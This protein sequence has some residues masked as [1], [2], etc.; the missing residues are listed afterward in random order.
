MATS[1]RL[2]RDAS[3]RV[4]LAAFSRYWLPAWFGPAVNWP[5]SSRLSSPVQCF[6]STMITPAAVDR[7]WSALAVT[8]LLRDSSPSMPITPIARPNLRVSGVVP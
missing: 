2:R 4:V 3:K 6:V 1:P 5:F 8:A 7:T